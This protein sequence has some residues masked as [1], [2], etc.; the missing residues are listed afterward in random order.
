[1]ALNMRS[2]FLGAGLRSAQANTNTNAGKFQVQALFGG[3]KKKAEKQA[4]TGTQKFGGVIK[5]AQ[6]A[7]K[8]VTL[9]NRILELLSQAFGRLSISKHRYDAFLPR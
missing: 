4:K 1:M 2:D 9:F 3:G 7:V 6:K 5:Q 8:Q